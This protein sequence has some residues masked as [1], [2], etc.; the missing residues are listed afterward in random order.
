MYQRLAGSGRDRTESRARAA[1]WRAGGG[2]RWWRW[3]PRSAGC[4]SV[5]LN[6]E[7]DREAGLSFIGARAERPGW[8]SRKGG[9][10]GWGRAEQR[11]EGKPAVKGFNRGEDRKPGRKKCGDRC[12]VLR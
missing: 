1:Q 7:G 4:A 6:L 10:G 12:V 5:R 11:W 8:S 3:G 9:G 2:R